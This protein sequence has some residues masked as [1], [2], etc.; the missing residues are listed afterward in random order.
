MKI[1]DVLHELATTSEVKGSLG[2]WFREKWVDISRKNKDG[3]HPPCGASAG[4]K[5]RKGGQRAYPKCRKAAVAAKMSKKE[6]TEYEKYQEFEKEIES[7][8][9]E[10]KDN[11]ALYA[12]LFQASEGLKQ[13]IG[14]EEILMEDIKNFESDDAFL[15]RSAMIVANIME[16]EGDSFSE[17]MEYFEEGLEYFYSRYYY[18]YN[19]DFDRTEVIGELP[20]GPYYGNNDVRGP[21]ADGGWYTSA[22]APAKGPGH[23]E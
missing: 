22:A 14:K 2:K 3:S 23:R 18:Y 7:K 9:E 11:L 21:D 17:L 8:K 13:A 15:S 19:P 10:A 12:A 6:K 5:S 1:E 4:K 20:E 16:Q